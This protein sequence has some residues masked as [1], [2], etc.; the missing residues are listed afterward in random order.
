LEFVTF[1]VHASRH[2]VEAELVFLDKAGQQLN[3][4]ALLTLLG[5]ADPSLVLSAREGRFNDLWTEH[6]RDD[7]TIEMVDLGGT[8]SAIVN[9]PSALFGLNYRFRT[10]SRDERG[11]RVPVEADANDKWDSR[12]SAAS[13]ISIRRGIVAEPTYPFRYDAT[14]RERNP[15]K[16]T[17]YQLHVGSVLGS[18]CNTRWS[19]LGDVQRWLC[20]LKELGV[21]TI[22]LLP[23]GQFEK[24]RDWG[25]MG[26]TTLAVQ[27]S[28]SF[29]TET[30]TWLTGAEA[31]MCFVDEAHGHGLNVVNDVVYNH[32]G[33]YYNNLWNFDGPSNPYFNW[34]PESA[35]RNT[36]WGAMPAF[37]N[38]RVR[39]FIVDHAVA[40]IESFHLDGLRFDFTDPI[41]EDCRAGGGILE[42]GSGSQTLREINRQVHYYR[43]MSRAL[44]KFE[45][46][47]LLF[48]SYA[49]SAI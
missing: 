35:P 45:E 43:R 48:K 24:S 16:W 1:E 2:V 33:A 19:T 40:Q 25:Y 42:F 12:I 20:Y 39:Q 10:F 15:A 41:V 46:R 23:V 38:S 22:Q 31:L 36:S 8:F 27:N 49:A 13:G 11:V 30:G 29:P 34:S 17:I 6:V 3:K 9:R 44:L 37:S 47:A 14:P 7:G 32:I 18:A 4:D 5:Q 28:Y 21:T 26:A